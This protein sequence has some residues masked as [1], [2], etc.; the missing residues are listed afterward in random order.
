MQAY[1]NRV[2]LEPA[3]LHSGWGYADYAAA[4]LRE[5]LERC[6][7]HLHAV[8]HGN[9]TRLVGNETLGRRLLARR[10]SKQQHARRHAAAQTPQQATWRGTPCARLTP[11]TV[12]LLEQDELDESPPFPFASGPLFAVSRPLARLLTT[13]SYPREWLARLEATPVLQFYQKKGRVPFVLR[14]DACYPASFD[15]L[16]GWW[17]YQT[18]KRHRL[19]LTLV[20]TPFMIQHHPW[21]AFRHGA[22]SNSSIILHELKNP[23]SPGWAFAEAHGSGP[24]VPFL[25]ACGECAREMGWVTWPESP[26]AR[27]EC[28]GLKQEEYVVKA[29]C[30]KRE[31]CAGGAAGK[32]K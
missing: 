6:Q 25:R 31:R 29:Q 28:C 32:S 21:V 27:W 10:S 8:R 30:A 19:P 7:R 20:N 4:S 24:F 14:K 22:F 12:A 13:D 3:T 26:A 11:R 23:N 1:Y 16:S 15:A 9:G 5:R 2:T 18:T 17:A